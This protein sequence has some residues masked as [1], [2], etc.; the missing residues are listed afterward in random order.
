MSR[1]LEHLARRVEGDPFFLATPLV[2]FARGE[3]LDDSALAARLGCEVSTLT[4]LRLCRNPDPQPPRFWE[5]TRAIA[6]RFGLDADVLAGVI[7]HGQSL[8]RMGHAAPA[9]VEEGSGF[10]MAARED[11]K[12]ESEGGG[13]K[14]EQPRGEGP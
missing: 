6:A 12:D 8:V 13:P 2:C 3:G 4:P 7:R 5:D 14:G 10:L 9:P 1:P 11:E